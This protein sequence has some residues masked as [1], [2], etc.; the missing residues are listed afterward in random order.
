MI[1]DAVKQGFQ[2]APH[3]SLLRATGVKSEDFGKPF[4][5]VCNSFVEIIPGH[6]H[7]N[8]VGE[9]VKECIREA[10]GVPFEFN[11]IGVCDGIAMNHEDSSAELLR[12]RQQI[13]KLPN[14]V[15]TID[16]RATSVILD[17]EMPSVF[18]RRPP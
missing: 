17:P 13:F 9:W 7:L 14:L 18:Q 10:G 3:R 16:L 15:A 1:S 12:S 5:A 4:V 6:V 2:R 11:T 8:K